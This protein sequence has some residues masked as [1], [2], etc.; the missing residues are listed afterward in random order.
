MIGA[1][2]IVII[3]GGIKFCQRS[4]ESSQVT[5]V[6][7]KKQR[8]KVILSLFLLMCMPWSVGVIVFMAVNSLNYK[9]M[10]IFNILWAIFIFIIFVCKPSVWKLLKLKFPWISPFL[11][12]CEK[13]G[14][15]IICLKSEHQPLVTDEEKPSNS[16]N[17]AG[18]SGKF[19]QIG[20]QR[21]T[22]STV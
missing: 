4:V 6:S 2:Y 9:I 13:L 22:E 1:N 11:S 19:T 21:H 10:R 12:T 17:T 14:S 7:R 8:F 5:N 20:Y 18:I 15:K 16:K 3:W